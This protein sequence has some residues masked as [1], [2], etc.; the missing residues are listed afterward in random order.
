MT[1]YQII[2]KNHTNKDKLLYKTVYLLY[3]FVKPKFYLKNCI[4]L[5]VGVGCF[6]MFKFGQYILVLTN[7]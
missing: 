5:N 2:F 7:E 6:N 1:N 3:G 4:T